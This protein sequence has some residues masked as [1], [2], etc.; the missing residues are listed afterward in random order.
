M[1]GT[2]GQ[3]APALFKVIETDTMTGWKQYLHNMS[4]SPWSGTFTR[5]EAEKS[6]KWREENIT[7]RYAYQIVPVEPHMMDN[8]AARERHGGRDGGRHGSHRME[9]CSDVDCREAAR[10]LLHEELDRRFA[11]A[12]E[13]GGEA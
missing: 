10:R 6:V 8:D 7:R 4:T 12:E 2:T 9:D 13:K 11:G 1:G 3:E 5:E